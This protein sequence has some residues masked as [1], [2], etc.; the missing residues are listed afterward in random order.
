MTGEPLRQSCK[1]LGTTRVDGS[2]KVQGVARVVSNA[3]NFPQVVKWC[4]YAFLIVGGGEK[5]R[6]RERSRL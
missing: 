6:Q 3:S 1:W 2:N 5:T 4:N